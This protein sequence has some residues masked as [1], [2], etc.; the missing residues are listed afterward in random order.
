MIFMFFF[1][2][3]LDRLRV[4]LVG[5]PQ[6]SKDAAALGHV[7]SISVE[8]SCFSTTQGIISCRLPL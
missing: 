1:T 2:T 8:Q 6:G 5:N 3:A 7:P 4:G